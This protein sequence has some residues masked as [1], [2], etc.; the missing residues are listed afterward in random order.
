VVSKTFSRATVTVATS[1][2]G[3][4]DGPDAGLQADRPIRMAARERRLAML[5]INWG[6]DR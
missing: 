1:G 4:W 5:F 3:A 6:I 2:G